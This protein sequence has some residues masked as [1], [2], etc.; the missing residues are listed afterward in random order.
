[1]SKRTV[2]GLLLFLAWL[3]LLIHQL[4][5]LWSA[6]AESFAR[7]PP[8]P[9]SAGRGYFLALVLVALP[10]LAGGFGGLNLPPA[11][12]PFLCL[13]LA[14]ACLALPLAASVIPSAAW[15]LA[16]GL[17]PDFAP[18]AYRALLV[19]LPAALAALGAAVMLAAARMRHYGFGPEYQPGS[20]G[21]ELR[22]KTFGSAHFAFPARVGLGPR[23]GGLL[24]GKYARRE[25]VLPAGE[26]AEHV[27]VLGASGAGKSAGF[28]LPNLL[29]LAGMP[30]KD[31]PQLVVTDPKGE[32]L[33]LAG[34]RLREAG[35][36]LLVF[37][38]LK[39]Q[40]SLAWNPLARV[41]D[42][43]DAANLAHT[44]IANTGLSVVDPYWSNNSQL[45]TTL[46]IAHLKAVMPA[47]SMSHVHAFLNALDLE[48]LEAA[49]LKSPDP[50]VR[51]QA[52][53]ALSRLEGNKKLLATI[54]SDLPHRLQLWGIEA[55]R[56]TTAADEIDFRKLAGE[57]KT[58]LFVITPLE[59]K[60]LLKPL[61]ASFFAGLFQVLL[62]EGEKRGTLPRPVWFFLDEFANLGAIASVDG[63]LTTCRGY[64]IGLVLGIQ[65]RA[66]LAELYG[67]HRA[68]TI[69]D[70]CRTWLIFP[71]LGPEDAAW[72]SKNLLGV[73]T[74]PTES[75]SER[76]RF[77]RTA[78]EPPYRT[79]QGET[80][81]PLLTGDEIRALPPEALIVLAGTRRPCLIEQARW[82]EDRRWKGLAPGP[83][84][85]RDRPLAAITM[86]EALEQVLALVPQEAEPRETGA[87]E[88]AQDDLLAELREVD[89]R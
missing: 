84:P 69:Q 29:R 66:Q 60:D 88:S 9:A 7:I 36:S 44:I 1:M 33:R 45:L 85:I 20:A 2:V 27:L 38:P 83:W 82:Y 14:A 5:R 43:E 62:E 22:R 24:L 47:A 11:L 59:K 13:S 16:Q 64:G 23:P 17:G 76:D 65:S 12:R 42:Y 75:R 4:P 21:E 63:F 73:T 41:K 6:Y 8:P 10:L 50:T 54:L 53:G 30:D 72:V 78:Y 68:Q 18:L 52:A 37:H 61:F 70:N 46:A 87:S 48:R 26:V 40:V 86:E 15:D 35:Y 57:E 34:P 79:S 71:R 25:V 39:P 74:V 51:Y 56:A 89:M 55:V 49:L 67:P 80:H 77:Q 81:R 3:A 31:Q 19:L 58:A 32:L 28:F